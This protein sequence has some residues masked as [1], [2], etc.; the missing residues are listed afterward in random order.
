MTDC[1]SIR[2]AVMANQAMKEQQKRM[3]YHR[4]YHRMYFKAGDMDFVLEWVLGSAA[5]GGASIGESF[6]A[7][8]RMKDGDPESWAREWIALA[9]RVLDRAE[10]IR[11][12]GNSVSARETLLRAS[13]YCRAALIAMLPT[14]PRFR[15]IAA[16]MRECFHAGAALLD[17]PL[18]PFDIPF[19]GKTLP[20]YFQ[21]A[22][23]GNA[24]RPTLLT[25]GGGETFT[26]D[27]YY[28]I[29]P[30]AIKRGWNFATVDLPGQGDTPFQG[31][32]FRSDTEVPMK[33]VVDSLSARPD[34][35]PRRLAA[36]GISFGGYFVPRAAI[37]EKRL[38]ACV[39]N[40]MIYDAYDQ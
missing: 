25:I 38:R 28:Y 32:A 21:K 18:E 27:L 35:D 29:A 3:N 30:A 22:A 19:E 36:Y 26:E 9:D 4:P 16:A 14:D 5:N 6:H 11:R 40:S 10:E 37:F 15:K 7:A 34:V 31:L 17:P 8:S 2:E 12:A 1:S 33:P 20:G 13:I 39:A 23:A 24:R